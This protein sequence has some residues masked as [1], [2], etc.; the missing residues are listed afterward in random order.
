MLVILQLQK[1]NVMQYIDTQ[2]QNNKYMKNYGKIKE[3]SYLMYLDAN[4]L[5]GWA[6]SQK[7]PVDGFK[8]KINILK[9]N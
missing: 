8:W 2:K 6:M 3:S 4:S 7:F 9:F 1:V 5:Y